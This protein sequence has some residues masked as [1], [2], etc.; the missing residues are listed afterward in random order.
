MKKRRRE[1][2]MS[3]R[4]RGPIG[5]I[6][7]IVSGLALLGIFLAVL[8][9]FGGDIGAM[10]RWLFSAVWSFVISVRDTVASWGTFQKLF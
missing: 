1:G 6:I 9:Q 7:A 3:K 5:A 10:F 2:S 4:K 8:T